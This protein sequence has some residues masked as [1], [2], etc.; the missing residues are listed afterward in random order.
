MN[1]TAEQIAEIKANAVAFEYNSP[2][3]ALL[4]CGKS[5]DMVSWMTLKDTRYGVIHSIFSAPEAFARIMDGPVVLKADHMRHK[6]D[7]IKQFLAA[8]N[9]NDRMV[10]LVVMEEEEEDE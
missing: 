5:Y 8:N 4:G 9:C 2:V 10:Y 7:C 1:P 6:R 3:G